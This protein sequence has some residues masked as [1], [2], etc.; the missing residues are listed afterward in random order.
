[1]SILSLDGLAGLRNA[2]LSMGFPKTNPFSISQQH[3]RTSLMDLVRF[4]LLLYKLDEFRGNGGVL[5]HSEQAIHV[6]W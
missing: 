4:H 1:M 6:L 5:L 2:L 3:R